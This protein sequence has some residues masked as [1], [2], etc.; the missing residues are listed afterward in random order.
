MVTQ[1]HFPGEPIPHLFYISETRN[2]DA[3]DNPDEFVRIH[4]LQTL[5]LWRDMSH[6]AGNGIWC[7]SFTK[8]LE[9]SYPPTLPEM[10]TLP[11]SGKEI[12]ET[13]P[14]NQDF[15]FKSA[16]CFFKHQSTVTALFNWKYWFL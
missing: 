3:Q 13:V 12:L 10:L 15:L 8:T 1:Y 7:D 4:I 11:S 14:S 6:A 9:R 2:Q 16:V 5:Q